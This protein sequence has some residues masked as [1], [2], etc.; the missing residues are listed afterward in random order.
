[1]TTESVTEPCGAPFRS[2]FPLRSLYARAS[3]GVVW[4]ISWLFVTAPCPESFITRLSI[5]NFYPVFSPVL[6]LLFLPFHLFQCDFL[7]NQDHPRSVLCFSPVDQSDHLGSILLP[8]FL[9]LLNLMHTWSQNNPSNCS[10]QVDI[11]QCL[12]AYLQ[13]RATEVSLL[14]PHEMLRYEFTEHDK[15]LT[16]E[17]QPHW[18]MLLLVLHTSSTILLNLLSTSVFLCSFYPNL[19][20]QDAGIYSVGSLFYSFWICFRFP[21]LMPMLFFKE[22][23]HDQ[24]I[25]GLIS[26]VSKN[27]SYSPSLLGIFTWKSLH[28]IFR[29][30]VVPVPIVSWCNPFVTSHRVTVDRHNLVR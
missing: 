2:V 25:S 18:F 28:D 30:V 5:T 16:S 20:F 19:C 24:F 4:S 17:T 15:F 12:Y 21:I 22:T 13:A 29:T 1:M 26:R 23:D 7:Q 6:I 8:L 14:V 11:F 10:T 9:L 27:R 3:L